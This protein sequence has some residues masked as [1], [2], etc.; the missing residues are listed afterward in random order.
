M[1]HRLY[2]GCP[3]AGCGL[4]LDGGTAKDGSPFFVE[5][6]GAADL[7]GFAREPVVLDLMYDSYV[8]YLEG[9]FRTVRACAAATGTFT[10]C[11]VVVDAAELSMYGSLSTLFWIPGRVSV[12]LS[13]TR[14]GHRALL[15]PGLMPLPT[16]C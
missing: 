5:R 12:C 8:A 2:R 6:L 14:A 9:I 11:L 10:R 13:A 15:D 3:G 4:C 1:L 7:A 16:R